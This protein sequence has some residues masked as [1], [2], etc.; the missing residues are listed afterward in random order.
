M[1]ITPLRE[2]LPRAA[3]NAVGRDRTGGRGHAM[4]ADQPRRERVM[5]FTRGA[6]YR[7][8]RLL[9]VDGRGIEHALPYLVPVDLPDAGGAVG[10]VPKIHIIASGIGSER[11][12]QWKQTCGGFHFVVADRRNVCTNSGLPST[13]ERDLILICVGLVQSKD[14]IVGSA[15]SGRVKSGILGYGSG[16]RGIRGVCQLWSS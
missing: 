2:V 15:P 9:L 12:R 14:K 11:R 7:E 16:R 4:G 5:D 6:R 10:T 13:R 8:T 1:V 3:P